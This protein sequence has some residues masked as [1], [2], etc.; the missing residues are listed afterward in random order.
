MQDPNKA[1]ISGE[2]LAAMLKDIT[3]VGL[4]LELPFWMMVDDC[5]VYIEHR[6]RPFKSKCGTGHTRR[7]R[8]TSPIHASQHL[9]RRRS[10]RR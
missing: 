6:G 10:A 7:S 4:F 1:E 5:E 3:P 9:F 2:Q 8:A